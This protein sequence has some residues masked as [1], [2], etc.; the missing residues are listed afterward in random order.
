VHHLLGNSTNYGVHAV[1]A[2]V[3][4]R[5]RGVHCIRDEGAEMLYMP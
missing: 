4:L 2:P 5:Q 1:R 3:H